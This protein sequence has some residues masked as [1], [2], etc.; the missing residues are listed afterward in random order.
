VV[1]AAFQGKSLSVMHW[2]AGQ[3]GGVGSWTES[4]CQASGST[5]T[6]LVG[7]AQHGEKETNGLLTDGLFVLEAK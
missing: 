1:P 3:N 5:C 2:D 4:T 6:M 7:K